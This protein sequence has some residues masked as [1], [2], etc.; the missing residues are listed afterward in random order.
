MAFLHSAVAVSLFYVVPNLWSVLINSSASSGVAAWVDLNQTPL[1]DHHMTATNWAQV[2][3][4][5]S[6]WVLV[7]LAV[8]LLRV[9][10]AEIK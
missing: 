2:L 5:V 6:L 9:R 3:V 8:G 7:P 4:A 1:Y 10:R